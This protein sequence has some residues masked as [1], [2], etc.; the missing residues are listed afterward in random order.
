MGKSPGINAGGGSIRLGTG[1]HLHPVQ[2][3]SQVWF[4]PLSHPAWNRLARPRA[5]NGGGGCRRDAWPSPFSPGWTVAGSLHRLVFYG[6]LPLHRFLF[7]CLPLDR[8]FFLYGLPLHRFFFVNDL[9]LNRL[10]L[11]LALYRFFFSSRL[12]LQRFFLFICLSLNALFFVHRLALNR[13][14][15]RDLA[16]DT[17]FFLYLSLNSLLFSGS[18]S[19]NCF[20]LVKGLTLDGFFALHCLP[21]H[22]GAAAVGSHPL[23]HRVRLPLVNIIHRPHSQLGLHRYSQA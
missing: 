11:R 19:L 15:L 23:R 2:A 12:S 22:R 1:M 14:L 20:F 18:L 13:L 4:N 8:L 7:F 5:A 10:L 9:P 16:L 3:R 21:L 17:F 6:G